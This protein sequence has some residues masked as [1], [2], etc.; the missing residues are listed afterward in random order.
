MEIS[1][2]KLRNLAKVGKVGQWL[3]EGDMNAVTESYYKG[4]E[5]IATYLLG[6]TELCENADV[7]VTMD[8]IKEYDSEV[9]G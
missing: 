8:D 1:E 2:D 3:G 7:E 9:G 6:E 5:D 4:V